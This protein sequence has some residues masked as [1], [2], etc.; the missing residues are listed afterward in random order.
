MLCHVV[1]AGLPGHWYVVSCCHGVKQVCQVCCIMLHQAGP[2]GM[3]NGLGLR[4]GRGV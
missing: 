2:P 3:L 1:Q 4:L